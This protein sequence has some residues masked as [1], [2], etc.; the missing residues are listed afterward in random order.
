MY[1]RSAQAA[2]PSKSQKA[3]SA[4]APVKTH[5]TARKHQTPKAK[6]DAP[7]VRKTTARSTPARSLRKS[8]AWHSAPRH[9]GARTATSRPTR[10]RA[11][12]T[13]PLIIIDPGHGGIDPGA[14][15]RSG[16]LE[17]TVTLA[18]ALELR[19]RLLASGRY[20]VA[21]T[22]ETDVYVSLQR[23]LAFVRA[24]NPALFISLHADSSEDGAFHG[25]SVYVKSAAAVARRT[26]LR[27]E[28]NAPASA[29]H[30]GAAGPP[31]L[32]GMIVESLSDDVRMAP[33]PAR[34]ANLYVLSTRGI[35]S[36]L[37]EMGFLSNKD[38]ERKLRQSGH[39]AV[40]AKGIQE[41]VDAYFRSAADQANARS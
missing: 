33:D 29:G 19:R 2:V 12:A 35:P 40:I 41:A 25:A 4:K 20:R 5:V 18:A 32:Q 21:L 14:V 37:V 22:R 6:K 36:V 7:A 1:A 24:R 39:R 34:D 13:K 8:P 26:H 23:R 31:A 27:V 16:T 38:D 15:G 30:E 10:T 9:N 28:A 17:K 3:V 11:A